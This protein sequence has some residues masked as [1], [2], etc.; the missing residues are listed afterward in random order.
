MDEAMLAVPQADAEPVAE[1]GAGAGAGA[2]AA[3][4]CDVL[5]IGGGPAGC[6]AATLLAR[7]GHDVVLLEKDAHPRFHIGESLLPRNLAILDRLGLRQAVHRIGILK[8][9]AEFIADPDGRHV[10]FPFRHAMGGG[11]THA[12]Q[13]RRADFDRLLFDAARDAGV[14]C[15]ER[16]RATGAEPPGRAGGRQLIRARCGTTGDE[17]LFAP[18]YLLDASGRDTF[19]ASRG[20]GRIADKRNSTAALYAHYTGVPPISPASEGY[21]SVHLVEDGWF[22]FI[23]LPDGVTSVGFVGNQSAFRERGRLAP[24]A[25]FAARIAASPTVSARMSA[26]RRETQV[27]ATANYSYRAARSWTA[28]SCMIGDSFAFLDP[29]FSSGVLMAMTAGELGA[30]TA[31]LWLRDPVRGT[32][33]ARRQERRMRR[34]LDRIGWLI[35]RI[36]RPEMRTLFMSPSNQLRMRDGLVSLLAGHL[37]PDRHSRLPLLA[38]KLVYYAMRLGSEAARLGGRLRTHARPARSL[39]AA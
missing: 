9:G 1:A 20:A 25:L 31:S 5:V 27:Q 35:Y 2:G 28:S 26:A 34:A 23:P 4:P 12:Y 37:E 33:L 18:R 38:F 17:R 6:T 10:R 15:L 19:L 39:P 16:M 14:R 29:V 22:W 36:N 7:Q 24:D 32:A 21:I 13:V 3:E 11:D 8:P 30:E